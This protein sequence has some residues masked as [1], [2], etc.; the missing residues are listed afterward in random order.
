MS[1]QI[2]S[3]GVE[4]LSKKVDNPDDAA[5]L[6]KKIDKMIKNNKNNIL[7]LGYHQGIIF[8]KFKENNKFASAATKFKISRTT[9]NFKIDIVNFIDRHPKTRKSCISLFYLKNNFRLIKEVCQEH[10]SKFQ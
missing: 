5:Q 10:A 8:R 3:K 6:V 7:M 2:E 9:I 4:D 1:Q